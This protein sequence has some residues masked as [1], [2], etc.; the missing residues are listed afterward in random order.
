MQLRELVRVGF[1]E[2]SIMRSDSC[3][4]DSAETLVI[5]IT[6]AHWHDPPAHT[7]E[8][9]E[10][11][12]GTVGRGGVVQYYGDGYGRSEVA[13]GKQGLTATRNCMHR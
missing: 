8:S 7:E 4:F 5:K 1:R 2:D 11:K 13:W 10:R 9:E 12:R 6:Q 3:A